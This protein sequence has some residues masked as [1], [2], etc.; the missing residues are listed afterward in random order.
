LIEIDQDY[1][2]YRKGWLWRTLI[3]IMQ[4]SLCVMPMKTEIFVSKPVG[5]H[6]WIYFN[7]FIPPLQA[8]KWKTACAGCHLILRLAKHESSPAKGDLAG[9]IQVTTKHAVSSKLDLP[10][11]V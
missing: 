4:H 5:E 10:K 6:E 1:G 3:F 8:S 7:P 11:S 2:P 9:L